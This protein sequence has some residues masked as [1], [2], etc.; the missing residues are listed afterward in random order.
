MGNLLQEL[1]YYIEKY[2]SEVDVS[3]Q[4]SKAEELLEEFKNKYPLDHFKQM[5]LGEYALGRGGETYSWWIEYHSDALGSI[6]GGN[7]GKHIIYYSKNNEE[8][9]YPTS[10]FENESA[11]WEKL[12]NDFV[13]LVERFGNGDNI[14]STNLLFRA[15]M[16][17]TKTLYLFYPKKLLPVY[18]VADMKL[19]LE[20]LG[21]GK[22]RWINQKD[23]SIA[24][25]RLLKE[26]IDQ[27]NQ[28][29][30]WHPVKIMYFL[31]YTL[32]RGQHRYVKIA[33]GKNA[34]FWPECDAGNYISIGWDELGDL[35]KY[36]DYHEFKAAF[37]KLY[38]KDNLK[39]ASEKANEIWLFYSLEPG[40][41]IVVNKG[42]SQIL[43]VGTVTSE[44]YEYLDH[45]PKHRH[46]VHVK[47]DEGFTPVSIPEQKY[48]AFKTVYELSE[49][50]VKKWLGSF[51]PAAPQE[52]TDEDLPGVS[53]TEKEEA[54][55]K[56]MN[57]V[58][59]RKGQC[60]LYGPP[61]TG[62]TYSARRFIEWS[63]SQLGLGQS[64]EYSEICT[65]HPSYTYEDFMEGFKPISTKQGQVSFQL[66]NGIFKRFCE[67]AGENRQ[68]PHYFIID[69]LNRGNI[70]KIF[71]ELI[72]MLEKDKRNVEILLPQSKESFSIPE[73]VYIIATM[74][75]SDRSI[76]LMDAALKRRFAF[77]E[78]LPNYDVIDEVIDELAYSPAD[79][80][81]KI[82]QKLIEKGGR[83]RQIGQSYFM[84]SGE[85][86]TTIEQLKE[87]VEFEIIPLLQEYCFD[88]YEELANILG[89]EF[90]NVDEMSINTDMFTGQD[91]AFINAI[92]N[93]LK[94]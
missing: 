2:N 13:E 33:P 41:R 23:D 66:E 56:R 8:W 64:K 20:A 67:Q 77:I 68:V 40:D 27:I 16:L 14:D 92:N 6:R 19:F 69:E 32:K 29:A 83:D 36:P 52:G 84:Q 15:N 18:S 88:N 74:N 44:G 31:Y 9:I 60:I 25:N 72:T 53:F 5:T 65:F 26:T 55:F 71:G 94:G 58:L 80:L 70:P 38:Y 90:V 78:C 28:F 10:Q 59:E 86:I 3:G 35:S 76:K 61:G 7:A 79:I 62:K 17:K 87:V 22:D 11:A 46:A 21:V 81:T 89:D 47:W 54:F 37:Q 30:G 91:D 4:V 39:K 85:Q 45:L 1:D 82:N 51:E 93:I 57:K 73:N 43:A 49:K 12:R 42:T 63:F 48:W 24:L 34:E 50:D 75:T